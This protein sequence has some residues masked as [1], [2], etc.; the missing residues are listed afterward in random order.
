M[1][2]TDNDLEQKIGEIYNDMKLIAYKG[3]NNRKEPLFDCEC[4]HCKNV[5]YDKTYGHIKHSTL[6]KCKMCKVKQKDK[7]LK[8]SMLN[9]KFGKLTVRK[10]TDDNVYGQPQWICDCDCGNVCIANHFSLIYGTKQSCGCL[11]K[12]VNKQMFHK[13][14]KYDLSKEYGIGYTY[15]NEPFYFDLEDYDLIKNYC[16]HYTK[17][18]YVAAYYTDNNK[19][20]LHRL[21]SDVNDDE[22]IDHINHIKHDSRKCNLRKGDYSLNQRN[23]SLCKTNNSGT[24]GVSYCSD[25]NTYR[26]FI[27]IDGKN[28]YIGESS[29]IEEAKL[30]RL[31]AENEIYKEWSYTNSINNCSYIKGECNETK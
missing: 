6:N 22:I 27:G 23:R 2:Y 15:K 29:N 9:H 30:M 7:D 1:S 19:I 21:V 25:T 24:T 16:W 10:R 11:Y 8:S 13:N 5:L 17:D 12:D 3:R 18:G 26:A 4:I 20:L 14:N 28:K 31:Q